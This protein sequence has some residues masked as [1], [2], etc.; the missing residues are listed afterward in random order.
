[1]ERTA[2]GFRTG[3]RACVPGHERADE[4]KEREDPTG[5]LLATLSRGRQQRHPDTKAQMDAFTVQWPWVLELPCGVGG[6][7]TWI[8]WVM[9]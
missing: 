1:M 5:N 4:R 2:I 7:Q 9:V 8:T 6:R 3:R